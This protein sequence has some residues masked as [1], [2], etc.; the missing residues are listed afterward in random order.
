MRPTLKNR[1]AAGETVYSGW[2][3]T[4]EPQNAVALARAGFDAVTVDMQ[5]G[6]AGTETMAAMVGAIGAAGGIPI[7]RVP[8]FQGSLA[9]TALDSGAQGVIAP[10][11]NSAKD[12][13]WL[14]EATKFPPLGERS[15]GPNRASI[16][17]DM[18][19]G[20]MLASAND[21]IMTIPMIETVAA[22]EAMDE[23]MAVPGIDAVFVGPS[24]LSISLANGASVD[25]AGAETM[26]ACERIAKAAE[27]H[28]IVA[29]I[30]ALSADM[31]RA[32]RD[33]GY[34][35]IVPGSDL[36]I[37]RSGA[38]ALLSTVKAP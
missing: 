4:S 8:L 12:A 19:L 28:G 20:E 34:R 33:M 29:A 15:W 14:V 11:I 3:S 36:M 26:K 24:D 2:I 13:E 17:Y 1:L 37:L 18:P 25:P 38:Q 6:V 21:W 30:F 23:I 22:M 32:Y 9:G 5:H 31:A 16:L 35:L 7:V 27:K 10:M